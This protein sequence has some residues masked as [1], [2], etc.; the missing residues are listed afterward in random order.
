MSNA[1]VT[2]SQS[3]PSPTPRRTALVAM[4]VATVAAGWTGPGP[5]EAMV[6]EHPVERVVAFED[7]IGVGE[8]RDSRYITL[9]LSG[10]GGRLA[11][12]RGAT[13][14]ILDAAD[15][16]V[17]HD[18]G[19]GSRPRWSPSGETLGFYS[20][21]SG[22]M[23]LWLW[24][25][26]DESVRRLTDFPDGIDPDPTTRMGGSAIDA[27]DFSWSPDGSRLV[28]A[29]RVALPLIGQP[30]GGPL[31][32]DRTTAP[33]L[34]LAGIFTDPSGLTGGVAETPDGKRWRYRAQPP[35]MRLVSRL[36]VAD[37]ATDTTTVLEAGAGHLFHPQWSPDG[38][39][40]LFAAIDE[41]DEVLTATSGEIRQ[42]NLADASVVTVAS[43]P[44]V[45]QRPRWSPDGDRIAY[46]VGGLKPDIA[47]SSS[48]GS[49]LEV[50]AFGRLILS[51]RWAADGHGLLVSHPEGIE[52]RLERLDP[53]TGAFSPVAP[54][55][56][57]G[58][59]WSQADDG[60]LTWME[61]TAGPDLWIRS[62]GA[63]EHRRL[64]NSA[65][66]DA[67]QALSLGRTETIT[68]TNARGDA[69]E[70]V[71]LYPPD[72]DP[73]RIYP[74]I[75]DVYPL[76]RGKEWMTA[77]SGN[78]AW[79][80]AGY[81]VFKP[82][83]RAP[84]VWV[85]CSGDAEF[86]GAS[87]GPGGWDVAVQDVMAGVDEVI[88]RG[89]ADSQRICAYGHSN[90]GG[91][92]SYLV[93]RTDRFACAVIVAPVWPSWIGSTLLAPTSWQFLADLAG[94][95]VLTDPA[96]YVAL[97]AVF[98]A[99]NVTTPVLLAAGDEDGMFLLGAIEMYNA[100]RFAEADVTLLR[101]PDQGHIFTGNALRDFWDREMAF[102]KQHLTPDVEH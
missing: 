87:R 68:Y 77:L 20:I 48:E 35:G 38:S 83:A 43:G 78:Q 45:K 101:Y 55:A 30:A 15:G 97:S 40:I 39:Q 99:R 8:A 90:G 4:L 1:Y 79:A 100:L 14:V 23:Q 102:F 29:S 46:L 36:F 57:I 53:D 94:V 6:S 72:Y 81:L 84:H 44:G 80:A 86:C 28:F 3:I 21:R 18:L 88:R 65:A 96:A 52:A 60:A 93:T 69:L 10:D 34:T 47:V 71:L 31:I 12:A 56:N 61:G 7:L 75:V 25:A 58:S 67:S 41:T 82:Y 95:D 5:A 70:G 85:A 19:E 59:L 76:N 66:Q 64:T 73:S 13:L 37:L 26:A 2:A 17:L 42:L 74:M 62:L 24:S 63:S 9:D 50:Q 89:S 32:L 51:Y 49:D 16:R 11:V 33:D 27:Y 22:K 54:G 91:L 98:R 92:A